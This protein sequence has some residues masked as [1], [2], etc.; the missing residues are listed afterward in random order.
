MK[1]LLSFIILPEQVTEFEA[2]YLKRMN[3][4]GL[5]FF[6]LHL[7]VFC[8]VAFFN[9]TDPILAALLTAAV[10]VGP[11]AAN[12]TFARPRAISVVYGFTAML[13]G[14][15]LVHF[16]QGPVQIE[17][18]FYFFALLAMLAVFAN[19]M[20]IV[21]AAVTVALHHLVLWMY[22]PSSVFNYQAP[23]WVVAVH[24]GFVVLE[25]IAT[26]FIARSF[27]DNVIGLEKIVQARTAE[28]D[29]RNQDMKLVLDSVG[30]GFLTI[31]RQ[32]VMSNEKSAIVEAWLGTAARGATFADYLAPHVPGIADMFRLSWSQVVENVMPLEVCLDQLPKRFTLRARHYD[33]GYTPILAGGQL[34]KALVVVSDVTAVVERE[35]LEREQREVLQ[36][37][38]SLARDKNGFMEFFGE[39]EELIASIAAWDSQ[40]TAT[41][42]RIIHTLKG[43]AMLFGIQSIAEVCHAMEDRIVEE[44]APPTEEQRAEL[45][46]HWGRLATN[47]RTLLGEGE[48]IRLEID[49]QEY[50]AVLAAVLRGRPREEVAAMI[51]GWKLEPTARRLARVAE[52]ARG[53][54]TRLNK[55]P[56]GVNIHDHRLRLDAARW[57][58]FWSAFVHVV[59]NAIDHGLEGPENRNKLG[60]PR[61]G[62][63]E[64]STRVE[65]DSF[66]VEIWDDGRGIDWEAVVEKAR[67]KHIPHANKADLVEA[68]FQDGFSTAN[69]V[70]EFSGRGIGLG[71]VRAACQA[72]AGVVSVVSHP[73][74]GTCLEFRFP[75]E[76]MD[77]EAPRMLRSEN[78]ERV[79]V[80]SI[81]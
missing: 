80:T 20:V 47:S 55:G 73:G 15:L 43:N 29:G 65:G 12:L 7:P 39:A 1:Q 40:D 11:V 19:P 3:R 63:L 4:I 78:L 66:V 50:Q 79:G 17:M 71:A 75:R 24:A 28:L 59:R 31:D 14:G 36:V 62:M 38:G 27:F 69:Q 6:A 21:V 57:A 37:F 52:Q 2:R 30:Q 42:K 35:Q 76:Q 9:D 44:G 61:E 53:I 64:L 23:V 67:A 10:L 8:T 34:E 32:G 45:Q 22:L 72:R 5:L 58:P 68:L 74:G 46:A 33:L 60:K 70:S 41:L 49:E 51:T 16:G 81:G 54:A 13:M 26:C 56:I 77:A 25:S 18:H 48:S